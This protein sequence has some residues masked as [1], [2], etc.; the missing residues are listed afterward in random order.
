VED[1]NECLCICDS[2]WDGQDC[3][4]E[5]KCVTGNVQC[6]TGQGS[7]DHL[8]GRCICKTGFE[9]DSCQLFSRDRFLDNGQSGLWSAVD[10]CKLCESCLPV[11][12][13][14]DSII[15]QPGS[16]NRKIDIY[17]VKNLDNTVFI[18]A[19]VNV[20]TF[21][22]TSSFV[23]FGEIRIS[24]LEGTISEDSTIIQVS[25]VSSEASSSNCSGRWIR[26]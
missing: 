23:D 9:G 8:T 25:Y 3:T 18:T 22:Q 6:V 12:F 15:I 1:F 11:F 19:N 5:D 24:S 14:Y 2:G 13:S 17:N 4:L 20:T 16:D 7:C 26:Q 10:T 21:N